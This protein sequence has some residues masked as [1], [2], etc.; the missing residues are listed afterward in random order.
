MQEVVDWFDI[1]LSDLVKKSVTT[2]MHL[3]HMPLHAAAIGFDD[4]FM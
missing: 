1:R 2:T 3:V 4:F